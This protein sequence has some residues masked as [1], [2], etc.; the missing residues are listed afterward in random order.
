MWTPILEGDLAREARGA[1][2]A[3]AV[4]LET[5][6]PAQ[7]RTEHLSL[8]WGEAGVALFLDYQAEA[9]GDSAARERA[10][11]RLAL[12]I[13]NIRRAAPVRF[14]GGFPGI[15]WTA[16]HIQ[17]RLGDDDESAVD[18]Y[19]VST[20]ADPARDIACDFIDGLVGLGVLALARLPR[21]TAYQALDLALARLEQAAERRDDQLSWPQFIN[22]GIRHPTGVAHGVAGVIAL[23]ARLLEHGIQVA[24]VRPLLDGALRWL[25]SVR[26]PAGQGSWFPYFT[27]PDQLK[28]TFPA[29][30]RGDAGIAMALLGAARR[31]H[32]AEL[33]ER[34][35]EL[36]LD[37]VARAPERQSATA[38][39]CCGAAGLG[40]VFNRMFHATGDGRFVDAAR[41]CFRRALEL[42]TQGTDQAGWL[43]IDDS[44][45]GNGRGIMFGTAGIGLA[46]LAATTPIAP[47][48][49]EILLAA[50]PDA[51]R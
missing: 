51:T 49:D 44:P 28:G 6:F 23:L 42:R 16:A 10:S 46:M 34:A 18:D 45:L 24:R 20:L 15:A 14:H 31:T 35:R 7:P 36:A 1:I 37:V 5:P 33:E 12:V 48:W 38:R 50:I 17:R 4:A 21:P 2:A 30:C 29:W 41:A 32:D 13:E 9:A 26:K 47:A 27:E 22:G 19:L 43:A 25:F 3:I 39:V 11:D 40:H 8:G